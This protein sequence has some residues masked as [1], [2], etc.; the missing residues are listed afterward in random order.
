MADIAI[1]DANVQEGVDVLQ[2]MVNELKSADKA[3]RNRVRELR[4][5]PPEGRA[6]A[7]AD[8]SQ[9]VKDLEAQREKVKKLLKQFRLELKYVEDK[10]EY[11]EVR[12]A[13]LGARGARPAAGRAR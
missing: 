5:W 8:P 10:A 12:A 7:N 9:R 13:P 3:E 11:E 4:V 2:E 1:C 6:D